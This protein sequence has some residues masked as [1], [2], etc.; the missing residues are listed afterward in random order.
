MIIIKALRTELKT[1]AGRTPTRCWPCSA[2]KLQRRKTCTSTAALL[3][4]VKSLA[5]EI[6]WQ[7]KARLLMDSSAAIAASSRL[8][9]GK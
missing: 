3:L 1:R 5:E 6:G 2:S 8:G 7:L 4:F 9:M